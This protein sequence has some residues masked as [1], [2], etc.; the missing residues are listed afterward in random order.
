MGEKITIINVYKTLLK[1][2][3]HTAALDI[4]EEV[5]SSMRMATSNM[6]KT[7]KE[8]KSIGKVQSQ[9]PTPEMEEK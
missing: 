2:S 3:S 9:P 8:F 1:D 6:F 7:L 4:A 5:A